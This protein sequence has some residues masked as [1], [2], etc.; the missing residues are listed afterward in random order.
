MAALT[1]DAPARRV[2]ARRRPDIGRIGLYAFLISALLFYCIPLFIVVATSLKTAD[3]VREVSIFALPHHPG[4]AA[5]ARAWVGVCTGI[6]CSGIEI[7]FWNSVRILIPSMILSILFGALNGYALAQWRFRGANL[8]LSAIMIGAFIPYQVVLYPLVKLT[9]AIGIYGHLAGIVMVH[10]VFGLPL[11]TM[12][13]RNYYASLPQ[14]LIRAARMDGA[15]FFRIFFRIMLPLSTNVVIVAV[16]LQFTGIWND[17]LLG[18]VFAGSQNLPM[19]VQLNNLIAASRGTVE[20]NVNMAATLLTAL[21]PLL[22]YLISGRYF[23]SGIASGSV[24]G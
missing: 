22:V 24:K 1:T 9:A 3:E 19:T 4:F 5:W 10:V 13:F 18:Q 6:S 8:L 21:P 11:M 23:V 14:E 7:G 12:I 15:G 17:Y 20:H 2:A 16:I